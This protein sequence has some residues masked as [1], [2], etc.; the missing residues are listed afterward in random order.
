[1]SD[2]LSTVSTKNYLHCKLILTQAIF[3]CSLPG[4]FQS[5]SA[6]D[7]Y[8]GLLIASFVGA[9]RSGHKK[10]YCRTM[11]NAGNMLA[12]LDTIIGTLNVSC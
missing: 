11:F 12:S 4:H 10:Q 9:S 5:K 2:A 3:S 7:L 8:R 1:M 6:T